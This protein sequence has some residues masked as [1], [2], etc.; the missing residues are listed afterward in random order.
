MRGPGGCRLGPSPSQLETETC[1]GQQPQVSGA[2]ERTLGP[3]SPKLL[4][5]VFHFLELGEFLRGK[6]QE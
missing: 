5:T 4:E 2:S 3:T 6:E 1:G